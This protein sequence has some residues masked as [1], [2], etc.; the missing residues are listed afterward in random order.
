MDLVAQQ[1]SRLRWAE[2]RVGEV[3]RPGQEVL[4]GLEKGDGKEVGK[5]SS[6]CASSGKNDRAQSCPLVRAPAPQCP[7]IS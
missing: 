6:S 2:S 3:G 7:N 1:S 5:T 4:R